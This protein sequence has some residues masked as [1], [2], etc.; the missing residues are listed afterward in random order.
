VDMIVTSG[1]T[2]DTQAVMDAT[3]TVPIV[4]AAAVNRVRTGYLA[5][6]ARRVET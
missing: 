6:P 3:R 4:F 2:G 5:S 1:A